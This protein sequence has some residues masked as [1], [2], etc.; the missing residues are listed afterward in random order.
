[1]SQEAALRTPI[2]NSL[3]VYARR[4]RARPVSAL[5]C[6]SSLSL[7]MIGSA[8]CG[9]NSPA[10]TGMSAGDPFMAGAG[11]ADTAGTGGMPDAMSAEGEVP[12]VAL[13][14][15][16]PTTCSSE[17][18]WTRGN[19]ESPLMHPGRDCIDCH[20][21]GEG[22]SFSIAG[23]VYPTAHEPNDC[24]GV[25]GDNDVHVEITD[26]AGTTI[27]LSVN[28]AGNFYSTERVAYP[29]QAKVVTIGQERAM[30]AA[31]MTGACNSCHTETGLN[32][33]PGRIML[34]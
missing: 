29:I 20:S 15:A 17:Q 1:M 25:E 14:F 8:A 13:I 5:M 3:H 19:H 28:S 33:A 32:G 23:T 31:Q 27:T 7:L 34:P 18:Q 10:T 11:A 21:R 2:R 4:A 9:G 6:L 24:N 12:D 16:T 26:A 22:P 30:G